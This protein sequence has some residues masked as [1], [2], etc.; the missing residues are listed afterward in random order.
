MLNINNTTEF[1]L[2]L[3]N[4]REFRRAFSYRLL[5]RCRTLF[6]QSL[7]VAVF[8][9]CSYDKKKISETAYSYLNAM[10]NYQPS[11]ARPFATPQ[12]SDVTLSF[13]ETV[14]EH[15]DSVVYINNIPADITIG[16]INI[17]NDTCATVA[18]HKST[19]ST[20]Q[21]GSINLVKRGNQWLVDEVLNVPKLPSIEQSDYHK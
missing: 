15:T 13:Y 8:I 19:P 7:L 2:Q 9:S 16:E 17:F 18:F 5:L 10:G 4:V 3:G 20:Q 1:V 11:K 14:L 21:D 6:A 12:T